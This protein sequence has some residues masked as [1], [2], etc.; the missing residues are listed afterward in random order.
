[1]KLNGAFVHSRLKCD[2]FR[3]WLDF[4]G[5]QVAKAE[6][7]VDLQ[8]DT[9]KCTTSS[10]SLKC[11][12]YNRKFPEN[13][14]NYVCMAHNFDNDIDPN[15]RVCGA[16]QKLLTGKGVLVDKGL[17]CTDD[18]SWHTIGDEKKVRT[19]DNGTA[20]FCVQKRCTLCSKPREIQTDNY[21]TIDPIYDEGSADTCAK[22]TCPSGLW[23]V[24]IGDQTHEYVGTSVVCSS[25][26]QS[27]WVLKNGSFV[28]NIACVSKFETCDAFALNTACDFTFAN[29]TEISHDHNKNNFCP[30]DMMMYYKNRSEL[31]FKDENNERRNQPKLA[32]S[33]DRRVG[34]TVKMGKF[35]VDT[36][37]QGGQV[38]CAERNPLPVIKVTTTKAPILIACKACPTPIQS[39]LDCPDCS[40]QGPDI[41]LETSSEADKCYAKS[42][43]GG[44]IISEK[45]GHIEGKLECQLNNPVWKHEGT[46]VGK[47]AASLKAKD[48]DNSQA[49]MQ[50]STTF[51][52]ILCATFSSMIG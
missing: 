17:R 26:N 25:V 12:D 21:Y 47:F 2:I 40:Q 24:S 13:F 16:K 22:A 43:T 39:R 10:N 33:C 18:G 8:C 49:Q 3:G 34:W 46:E 14:S 36:I 32:L 19:A 23:I 44:G 7:V 35:V 11:A 9:V 1:M 41:A 45:L 30:G 27:K 29:C 31:T 15:L 52:L 4:E 51:I 42:V 37:G 48:A 38:I 6:D 20:A 28:D 50:S 5:K